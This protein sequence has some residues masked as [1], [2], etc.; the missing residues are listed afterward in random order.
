MLAGA[1]TGTT[2]RRALVVV[3][4]TVEPAAVEEGLL[5][6]LPSLTAHHRVV[7]ASVADPGLRSLR[8]DLSGVEGVYG[9]AA[10]ER[11]EALHHRTATG[12]EPVELAEHAVQGVG[13]Q[14]AEALVDEQRVQR[15]AAGLAGDDVG[16]PER[17]AQ[18]D[19]E[20]LPA[21]ERVRVAG[22]LGEVVAHP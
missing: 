2:R 10:A 14:R 21:R 17:Q 3:L 7:L 22:G 9:A 13:V 18:R 12:L 20:G 1:I 8:E 4:T 11:T 15:D 19:V 6:V 5:P 16:Q